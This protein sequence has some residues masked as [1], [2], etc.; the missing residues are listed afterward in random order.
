MSLADF[1]GNSFF[2]DNFTIYRQKSAQKWPLLAGF[3]C[4]LALYDTREQ[5]T[6][7]TRQKTAGRRGLNASMV[8]IWFMDAIGRHR[9]HVQSNFQVCHIRFRF[10]PCFAPIWITVPWGPGPGALF[11]LI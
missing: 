1:P 3:R 5:N 4:F 9:R 6:A 8:P 2:G 10:C 11:W 7:K